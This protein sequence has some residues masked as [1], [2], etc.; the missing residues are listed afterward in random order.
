MP[1][2]PSAEWP[3]QGARSNAAVA[4]RVIVRTTASIMQAH[5]VRGLATRDAP[6][7]AQ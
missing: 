3:Q 6:Y 2:S 1:P 5:V 4:V 7:L